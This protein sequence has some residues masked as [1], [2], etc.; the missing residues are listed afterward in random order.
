LKG[1]EDEE[2]LRKLQQSPLDEFGITYINI[3]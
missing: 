2:I 3:M 1:F